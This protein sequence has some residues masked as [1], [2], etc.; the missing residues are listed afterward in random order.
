MAEIDFEVKC[1][2]VEIYNE[3]IFDLLDSVGQSKLQLREDKGQTYLENC[4]ERHVKTLKEVLNVIKVGQ[5]NRHVASTSMNL[6]SSRSH[7]VFTAFI[8]TNTVLK[9]GKKVMR[10][11]RFHIVDL[12]GSERVK[13]T[14]ADGQRLRELC[15]I[16]TSLS[17]L[18]KV[19]FELS[20]NCKSE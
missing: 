19:I 7:A 12:A 13:D 5:E 11:S 14:N 10:S 4:V 3:T 1:S 15:K 9:D 8:K 20:E 18:G 17:T 6:E 2:Y 16:N